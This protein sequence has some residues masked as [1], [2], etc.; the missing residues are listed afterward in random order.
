M[1]R[2]AMLAAALL[3]LAAGQRPAEAE[4]QT[5][6]WCGLYCDIIYAGCQKT[7]GLISE[8]ACRNFWIGCQDGCRVNG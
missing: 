4:A 2:S 5:A 3:A 6:G 7:I 8:G 1:R